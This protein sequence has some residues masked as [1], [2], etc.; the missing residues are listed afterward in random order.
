MRIKKFVLERYGQFTDQPFEFPE[1]PGIH[2]IFGPNEA[3]KSTVLEG[4]RDV[5]FGIHNRSTFNFRHGYPDM[6]LFAEIE[7][8]SGE[9]LA[10]Y[11]RKGN[12]NTILG[13]DETAL[14]D[15]VLLPF[16]GTMDKD[17]FC[18]MF[19]L[20]QAGL[21]AGGQALLHSE[22]DA[23]DSLFGA[24]SGLQS[25]LTVSAALSD[26]ADELFTPRR[27]ASRRY[28]QIMARRDVAQKEL[29]GTTIKPEEWRELIEEEERVHEQQ[30]ELEA[31][32][33]R[34]RTIQERTQRALRVRPVIGRIRAF[35]AEIEQL[36]DLPELATESII[37]CRDALD[38]K[39]HSE[40]EIKRLKGSAQRQR[41]R[42]GALEIS[43]EL[44]AQEDQ[45]K[46]MDKRRGRILAA[47]DD[48]P[49]LNS[50]M[51]TE[52]DSQEHYL[53]NLGL[54]I[55]V[56]QVESVLPRRELLTRVRNLVTEGTEKSA[57]EKNA[58]GDVKKADRELRSLDEKLKELPEARNFSHLEKTLRT[59]Q[60]K[61]DLEKLLSDANQQVGRLFENLTIFNAALPLWEGTP[62]A[63]RTLKVPLRKTVSRF[64]KEISE[65]E[66]EIT[67]SSEAAKNCK[68]EITNLD[69]HIAELR[70]GEEI[71]T[72]YAIST[73]RN[74]RDN[75]WRLIRQ[76]YLE[77][78]DTVDEDAIKEYSGERGAA[79]VYEDTVRNADT[80]V[81]RKEAEA[82]RIAGLNS[83]TRQ[84]DERAETLSAIQS[85]HTDIEKTLSAK[86]DE[87]SAAWEACKILPLNPA[88]MAAWLGSRDEI[89]AGLASWIEAQDGRDVVATDHEDACTA[90][91]DSLRV[92][93]DDP[94]DH[95]TQSLPDL[96]DQTE[97]LL[98]KL[99]AEATERKE[100]TNNRNRLSTSLAELRGA[101]EDARTQIEAWEFDWSEAMQE[102]GQKKTLRPQDVEDVLNTYEVLE[103]SVTR[104]NE[105]QRRSDSIAADDARFRED[106]NNLVQNLAPDIENADSVVAC[107]NLAERLQRSISAL[108]QKRNLNEDL[109]ELEEEL[110]GHKGEAAEA[111][112][113]L[114][115]LRAEARC[116]TDEELVAVH[117]KWSSYRQCT[118][119]LTEQFKELAELGGGMDTEALAAEADASSPESDHADEAAAQDHIQS[120]QE[121]FKDIGSQLADLNRRRQ[122]MEQGRGADRHAQELEQSLAELR[123]VTESYIVQKA[124]WFLL[125]TAIDKVREEQEAPILAKAGEVF[126][127]LTDGNFNKLVVNYDDND[128]P[129][130]VGQ[131]SGGERVGVDGMSEG[132][133]DQ[134][135]LALRLALIKEYLE[136][137][138]PLPF[139]ADDL[140]VSFDDDRAGAAL[141]VLKT[142]SESTQ[143]LVFT[144]HGH[145]VD[146]ARARLGNDGFVLH[147]FQ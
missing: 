48:S 137:A 58:A 112:R 35:E 66:N 89:I 69:R 68:T 134:L 42:I 40:R 55:P 130:L 46:G 44:I 115:K 77:D 59:V 109:D 33:T 51:K 53:R 31:E 103:K 83:M 116:E 14:P 29:R 11:R 82:E 71:P 80:L 90:I 27:S 142:M 36:G 145:L 34:Q 135:F 6:R 8:S 101:H 21:R 79:D 17:R 30:R 132:T 113:L 87:W 104:Q 1:T 52:R 2:L 127:D 133:R 45:I 119:A 61:G 88:E 124:A 91:R 7:N 9:A 37:I 81:D 75:G 99:T 97:S 136:T 100:T 3:G 47:R 32:M 121:Q 85:R 76:H 19:G 95:D 22:G 15:T 62:E 108:E 23:A 4:L 107:T 114:E 78:D 13:A 74:V 125:Q 141:N 126:T 86:Q 110:A 38:S 60:R 54:D 25:P 146:L 12:S 118:E 92:A 72:A 24:A 26:K 70:S 39:S 144:H 73:A 96:L 49:G 64:E 106:V 5:L 94:Q 41:D 123:D 131:R 122:E 67:R 129:V 10:F 128:R 20:N 98:G 138:E 57:N 63:L 43:E 28:Y 65:L 93:E 50:G 139:I 111:R 140:L 84:K 120:M 56:E 143:V 147:K 117:R 16:L 102:L 105:L 18:N